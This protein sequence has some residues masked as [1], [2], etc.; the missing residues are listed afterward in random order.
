MILGYIIKG[1]TKNYSLPYVMREWKISVVHAPVEK[2]C[3]GM[4]DIE[5]YFQSLKAKWAYRALANW[6]Q[7]SAWNFLN[8]KYLETSDA[9]CI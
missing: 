4:I 5:L 6:G 9:N 3:L 1:Q 7:D 8:K 2:G